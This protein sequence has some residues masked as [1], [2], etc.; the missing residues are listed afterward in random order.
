MDRSV[1]KEF[2]ADLNGIKLEKVV[3]KWLTECV[4]HL[5]LKN[6]SS[7]IDWKHILAEGI[8]VDP[9]AISLVGS[10]ATGFSLNPH[11]NFKAFHKDSDVDI[12]VISD[13]HFELAWY[14]MRNLGP[15]RHQF[16]QVVKT[17]LEDHRSRLV[18]FGTIATDKILQYLPFGK[19]WVIASNKIAGQSPINGRNVNIRLYRDFF[20]LRSYQVNTLRMLRGHRIKSEIEYGGNY[21]KFS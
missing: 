7:Y 17:A 6:L 8:D 4:P 10:A 18:Y 19:K 3:S 2:L 20:A 11:K 1:P 16:T 13:I 12:A 5:F 14:W 15:E 21:A 9:R